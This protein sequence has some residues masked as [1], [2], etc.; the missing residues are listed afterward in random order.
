VTPDARTVW[1]VRRGEAEPVEGQLTLAEG[2]LRFEPS[3]GDG[4]R[5]GRDEIRGGRRLRG[6]P[7]LAVSHTTPEGMRESFFFFA[8]P[9]PL[10]EE[11]KSPLSAR[12][13]QRAGTIM[14]LRA[15]N[16]QLKSELR[17]W[18]RAIRGLAAR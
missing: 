17:G 7:V 14:T 3:E 4:L 18:V 15:Q 2:E 12:G 8:R 13:L 10:P 5:L 11:R 16:K 6:S 9:P 1:L